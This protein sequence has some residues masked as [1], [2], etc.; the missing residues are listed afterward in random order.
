MLEQIKGAL[1][2]MYSN[3][4]QD[5]KKAATQLLESFQKSK[6]AWEP[7]HSILNDSSSSIEF[8]LFAA[9]TLRSKVTYDLVQLP[10]QALAQLKDSLIDLLKKYQ[11][12]SSRIIR[13]QLCVA[14]SQLSL[15]YLTW[16]NAVNEIITKLSANDGAYITSLLEFLKVLPE[17]LSDVKKTSLT[18]E[19]FNVRTQQLISSQVESVLTILSSL[20]TSNTENSS[21]ILDCLNSWIKECPI[22]TFLQIASLTQLI[23][24]SL[25]NEKT[26][27][28]SI[29]CLC[30]ILVETRDI[31]NHE[32]IDALYQQLLQLYSFFKEKL[33]KNEDEEVYQGITRLFVEAGESWH[34]LIAKNP[35]HFK[36]LVEIL[37]H[38]CALGENND[39]D[40]VK[41]TFMFWYLLKQLITLP[42]FE[43]SKAEFVPI[44]EKLILIIIKHL[45]YPTDNDDNNLFE[46]DKEEED[47]FK[48]FRYEMGDVL[49]DCCAVVGP[50]RALNVPFQQ[51]QSILNGNQSNTKW[52]Y[53][54]AP[55]FSM[56]AMAKEVPLKEKTILPII[57]KYL[58]SLP[59]HPK[60]RYA[61]TLVLGRYTEWTSKNP[62]FLEPQLNYIIKGFT[63]NSGTG[64]AGDK[65]IIV[66]A[67]HALM[68]FCQDC[69][70][71]L[72]NYLEQLYLLYVQVK[73]K[74]DIE[75][76]YELSDGLAHVIKQL[77]T[78]NLYKTIE[79]FIKPTLDNLEQ[80]T[81]NNNN[82]GDD[83]T[84][85]DQVE[86]ITMFISV[87]KC[88]DFEQPSYP[89]CDYFINSI[90]PVISNILSKYGQSL[91]ISER[92][93]KLIKN[94]I[95][96]FSTYLIPIL[97]SIANILH[98]GFKTTKFG[99]YLWVSGILIREFGDEYTSEEVKE[100]VYQF[101]IQQ[102]QLFFELLQNNH[103]Q[104]NLIPDVIEDFF[105][106]MNDL[107][108]FF[109]FKMIGNF[110]L[111]K[112][113]WEASMVSLSSI[114]QID[115][116][117]AILHY[118][119]DFVSWGLPNPPISFFEEGMEEQTKHIRS[120]VQQ[121]LSVDDNGGHL[122]KVL[123]E[124]LI[125]KNFHNDIQFDA[126]DLLIKILIVLPDQRI[127][128]NWLEGV[129]KSLP[130]V[131]DKEVEKL[132]KTVNTS[133]PNKDLRRIRNSLKDFVHW[134]TRKNVQP[135]SEF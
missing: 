107:L 134:Y 11:D 29:E 131:N 117:I 109:S 20:G 126:N 78:E 67:A 63:E 38:C 10:D 85:A 102:C 61:A 124:G 119:I 19:E 56:R 128:I 112:S 92:I 14:L 135:R 64:S 118:L 93:L 88:K 127:S 51:I 27:D 57:M 76:T 100:S 30:T 18:D 59:E 12:H 75:S 132:L 129:I 13:T 111:L 121:F 42:K 72:V 110:E 69:S 99:C 87:L 91:V 95:Q 43:E 15:Q 54:E 71:L 123:I 89:I 77:P 16:D 26:F 46:G 4:S 133:L 81:N 114:E 48:E 68:F 96:S 25:S 8:K 86:I 55:L 65:D 97:P 70:K 3:G 66:A 80:L 6:D 58:V 34:V 39:L 98:E 45:T 37:L 31:E 62:S 50:T 47:K 24:Q 130:N 105:R 53:L 21:L 22:E 82:K 79:M 94:A 90:W 49:K 120:I 74:L 17:E 40:V 1:G 44:Y 104:L 113:T 2:V 84:I 108:M 28:K 122:M 7:V 52:Q 103:A 83:K 5:E 125:F 23:F 106:M 73:D 35:K 101:S 36:P 9:Q 115:S 33:E 41:Y 116:L 60:V 32:L